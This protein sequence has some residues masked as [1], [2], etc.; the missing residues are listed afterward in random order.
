M[1]KL[2]TLLVAF[3]CMGSLA[4]AEPI[5]AG[6]GSYILMDDFD[7]G[8]PTD[9]WEGSCLGC[10]TCCSDV[11]YVRGGA[12]PG[13]E[14][15][16]EWEHWHKPQSGSGIRADGNGNIEMEMLTPPWKTY[17]DNR[18]N[19]TSILAGNSYA[20]I[21]S[22][23]LPTDGSGGMFFGFSNPPGT[24]NKGIKC[25]DGSIYWAQDDDTSGN[26]WVGAT[27]NDV[28]TGATY[29]PGEQFSVSFYI[30]TTGNLTIWR[31]AGAMKNTNGAGWVDITPA[32][33]SYDYASN[34]PAA[35]IPSPPYVKN[36]EVMSLH[37]IKAGSV[38]ET[39]L[40]VVD[41][42]AWIEDP[43]PMVPVELSEFLLE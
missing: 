3:T 12:V 13:S 20:I 21:C 26:I 27:A 11:G 16:G 38:L 5:P 39:S 37:T 10:G 41:Y 4:M 9:Y 43:I 25:V 1:R 40:C 30:G 8:Q 14:G 23:T 34:M 31:H 36:I 28:D 2:S 35:V 15:N 42:L 22:L 6:G 24:F 7:T 32:G 17:I 19:G 18:V 29:T 33:V